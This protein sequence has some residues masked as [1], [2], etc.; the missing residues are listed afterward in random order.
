MTG[1]L[2]NLTFAE[3]VEEIRVGDSSRSRVPTENCD[4]FAAE[5]LHPIVANPRCRPSAAL[6]RSALDDSSQRQEPFARRCRA[7]VVRS[8]RL[9]VAVRS[10]AACRSVGMAALP[11]TI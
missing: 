11:T 1:P 8:K 4:E 10:V 7:A 3:A 5:R 2:W 9:H 6:Q